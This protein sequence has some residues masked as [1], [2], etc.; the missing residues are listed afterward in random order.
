VPG[1]G[2]V[3]AV[4]LLTLPFPFL[5]C[6]W[7]VAVPTYLHIPSSIRI[8]QHIYPQKNRH[9]IYL[10]SPEAQPTFSHTFA[11][12]P[13]HPSRS[14]PPSFFHPTLLVTPPFPKSPS[15]ANRTSAPPNKPA[16]SLHRQEYTLRGHRTPFDSKLLWATS[17]LF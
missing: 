2:T 3:V 7:D 12:R 13:N 1:K 6:R 5:T 10:P 15:D 8:I 17:S 16:R 11:I 4:L 14:L 9:L